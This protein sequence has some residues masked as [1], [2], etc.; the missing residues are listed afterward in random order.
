[1]TG[2]EMRSVLALGLVYA[3][4]MAGMFMVLPLLA[5]YA[6]S[7]QGGATTAQIS[8]AIGL[9]G[10]A[11]AALQIPLGI[12]SDRI[13][14]KPVIYMGLLVFAAGSVVAGLGHDIETIQLGR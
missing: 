8:L 13:G 2:T 9:Y 6:P 3:L 4:R 12:L 10:L 11:N 5:L 7:L 14:R 1:M